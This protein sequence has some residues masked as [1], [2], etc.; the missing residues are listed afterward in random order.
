[1]HSHE[2]TPHHNKREKEQKDKQEN[3]KR[4]ETM[5]TATKK[6]TATARPRHSS[7]RE[8]IIG[9]YRVM[10]V[11]S[12]YHMFDFTAAVLVYRLWDKSSF[13]LIVVG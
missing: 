9:Q 8:Q 6:K 5:A 1:M 4:G 2:L 13:H 11:A 7:N 12:N 10:I 3:R